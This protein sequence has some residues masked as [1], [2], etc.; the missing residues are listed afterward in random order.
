MKNFFTYVVKSLL[1]FLGISYPTLAIHVVID[2][3][4]Y[5]FIP[6]HVCLT[7]SCGVNDMQLIIIYL[8]L[9]GFS[10]VTKEIGKICRILT[11][12]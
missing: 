1:I 10:V 8:Y 3:V 9:T 4:C 6:E 11:H 12:I 5:I 7:V 2:Y